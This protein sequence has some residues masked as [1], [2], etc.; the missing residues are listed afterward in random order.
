[1]AG[2]GA[3]LL[4]AVGRAHRRVS[5]SGFGALTGKQAPRFYRGK[6]ATKTGV[7]TRRGRFHML[8][9]MLPRY[10]V[11][12]LSG[13]ALRPYVARFGGARP[14]AAAPAAGGA[15]ASGAAAPAT[16]AAGSSGAAPRP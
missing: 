14:A 7:H 3:A 10:T 5:A 4:S 8:E 2:F 11:P 6:G 1:M 15:P 9:S 16:T 13:F 12:D